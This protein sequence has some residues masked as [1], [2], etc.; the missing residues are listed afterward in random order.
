M[1]WQLI[2]T[3]APR[4]LDAGRTGFGTVAKHRA[5]SGLLATTVERFS[6]F[7]RLPGHDLK[8]VVHCH[9]ILTLGAAQF[10]VLS[11][12]RDAGSDYT[13]RTNH[14]A[15]HL[16]AEAREIHPLIKAGITPADVLLSMSWRT[17]WN[18]TPRFL[19]PADEIDLAS[20]SACPSHAWEQA[21]GSNGFAQLPWSP[22]AQRGCYLIIPPVVDARALFRESLCGMMDQAWRQTF[23]TSLEPNDDVADFRWIGMSP[24]SPLRGQ[25]ETSARPVFDLLQASTLPTPPPPP[26][27]N[28]T[29]EAARTAVVSNQSMPAELPVQN[30]RQQ[31]PEGRRSEERPAPFQAGEGRSQSL[32]PH[33]ESF[34]QKSDHPATWKWFVIAMLLAGVAAFIL[35]QVKQSQ[36]N[37]NNVRLERRIDEI[38]EKYHLKLEGTQDWLK[39]ESREASDPAVPDALISSYEECLRQIRQSLAKPQADQSV[40]APDHTQDDFQELLAAHEDWLKKRAAAQVPPGWKLQSPSDMKLMTE[41]WNAEDKAWRRLAD[42]FNQEPTSDRVDR[43]ELL[44]RVLDVLNAGER[45]GGTAHEWTQ[46]LGKL[47]ETALPEWIDEWSK[48]ES[49]GADAPARSVQKLMAQL[50]KR[51]NVPAW[52]KAV[53]QSREKAMAADALVAEGSAQATKARVA[54]P[55][56]PPTEE[57]ADSPET[58]FPIYVMTLNDGETLNSALTRLPELPV[59]PGMSLY[60][61]NLPC[62]ADLLGEPWKLLGSSFRQSMSS[63]DKI[64]WD[65]GK[66]FHL[67]DIKGGCRLVARSEDRHVLF[68]LR[69]STQ[70]T[71]A[72]ELLTFD[73]PPELQFIQAGNETQ[74]AEIDRIISRLHLVGIPSPNFHLRFEGEAGAAAEQK[75][76]QV[77][78]RK[79]DEY[80]I[81]IPFSG[82]EALEIRRLQLSE[83]ELHDGIKKDQEFIANLNPKLAGRE[84]KVAKLRASIAE[85]EIKL[86]GVLGQLEV[87]QRQEASV[88]HPPSGTYAMLEMTGTVKNLCRVKIAISTRTPNTGKNNP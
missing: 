76:Y 39:Q 18:E 65:G 69:I 46:L 36:E 14:I 61:G 24:T 87:L 4:L 11:C 63:N 66:L 79:A 15:H 51:T 85:K 41:R 9:R 3:S 81:R 72:V 64:Q 26:S 82:S 35:H 70:P 34:G 16:I 59:L 53:A 31:I 75:I 29:T 84:Q 20:M 50:G 48:L 56:L 38:W 6:Q 32:P 77:H 5:V 30:L 74:L 22:G 60:L 86:A 54:V 7:A 13:G 58:V 52:L 25:M 10:H 28:V 2:Y 37:Q 67:P 47:G 78:I 43:K 40:S 49:L 33:S 71:Q 42:C 73:R 62:R 88:I 80:V 8:R 19:D 83:T 68:D 17:A 55:V 45:P 44:K 21:T 1:A 12:L 23:T 27:N 57:N